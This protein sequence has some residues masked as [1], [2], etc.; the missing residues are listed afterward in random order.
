MRG[1]RDR[2]ERRIG[3]EGRGWV[4]TRKDLRD[5]APSGPIGV[6]LGRLVRD[7]MIRRIGRGLFDYPDQSRL[8]KGS[9]PPDIEKAAQAIARKHRWTITPEGA[10]AANLLGLSR[11]V[12]AKIVYLSD[13]PSRKIA[14]GNQMIEFR[15]ASPKDL[16]LDHYTSRLTAHALRFLGKDNVDEA[17]IEHLRKKLTTRER[18]C[19]LQD[20][21]YGTDWIL[22]VAQ[23]ISRGKKRG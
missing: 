3:H 4:F 9:M 13:G 6:I 2:I 10:M 18:N 7:G 21:R 16:R 5:I 14:V 23:A 20:A 12:P 19:F 17:V 15:N 8:A 1:L 11:Q 22:D